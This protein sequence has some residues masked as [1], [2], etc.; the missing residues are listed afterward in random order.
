[1]PRLDVVTNKTKG[2]PSAKHCA[3]PHFA[4]ISY[5][6]SQK[7]R[8]TRQK[9]YHHLTM[10]PILCLKCWMWHLRSHWHLPLAASLFPFCIFVIVDCCLPASAPH[11]CAS[12][13]SKHLLIWGLIHSRL[14]QIPEGLETSNLVIFLPCTLWMWYSCSQPLPICHKRKLTQTFTH[15][16]RTVDIA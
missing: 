2:N 1:M 5:T 6:L 15:K 13:S 16:E 4:E 9:K 10:G 8:H 12:V 14:I 7:V 3:L 11:I